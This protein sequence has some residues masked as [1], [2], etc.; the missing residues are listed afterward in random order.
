MDPS[1]EK[2]SIERLEE[3]DIPL[4]S[5]DYVEDPAAERRIT[6]KLDLHILPWIF[7]LWLL[8]FI[9]RSNIGNAKLDGLIDDLHLDG[10]KYNVALTVF[11]ILYV[12]ID[13]PSNWLLKVVGGGRYLPILAAAWGI[14]GTCMGAVKSY[15][16]LIAC[17][18]LLGACEGGMFGG[19]I[20]YLSMFY[21]RHDLMFRL[22]VFYCA[23]PL[24]GAFGGLLATGLAQIHYHGYNGWPWI[25]FVEGSI[26][27]LVAVV[28]F[29]F[30]PNTP[31]AAKFLSAEEQVLAARRLRVDLSGAAA[32]ERVEEEKFNWR[33]VRFALLN[34]NT[35]AMSIN[36]FLILIPIYSFSLFLPTINR[37]FTSNTVTAQLYT[38][39]PNFL[40]FLTVLAFAWTSDR[41][42]M[43]GP[44][45]LVG[46]LLAAVGYIMEL[47]SEDNAVKYA[48]TF[49]VA[50]G[51][52]PC[53]PLVL[54]WL[55]NN[56]APHTTKAT[57][58]G[59]QVAFGNCGA[60]V[61]TFTYLSTDAPKYITGHAINLG[62]IGLAL[63][64]TAANIAY[65]RYENMAR[66]S[67]KRGYRLQ[68]VEDESQLGFLHPEFRYTM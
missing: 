13:I 1:T 6:R 60:F 9:D 36:F 61:A 43:R 39:A 5:I 41:F 59:F 7:A 33:E 38:V 14:V 27:V 42:K 63:L 15:G 64:L 52:F 29:F 40:G 34:I 18:L 56:L 31:G 37:S 28:A 53:S 11:Y 57:G 47:A 8:A 35:I 21:K 46:L 25:F 22:G 50:A 49:F 66:Q 16:G 65:I 12:L 26:T 45:I 20:L 68:M 4:S 10:D 24:S 17:R 54:A 32:T 19:I 23:A 2:E 62:A 44:F 48:G 67:G 30:L 3:K 58:L 55:S 51:A